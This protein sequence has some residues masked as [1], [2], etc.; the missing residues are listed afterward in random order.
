MTSSLLHSDAR[1]KRRNAAEK[2]FHLVKA[3]L[4]AH[5]RVDHLDQRT[6]ASHAHERPSRNQ[7]GVVERRD[8][9]FLGGLH[10]RRGAN[11]QLGLVLAHGVQVVFQRGAELH[12]HALGLQ[13][14]GVVGIP[15]CGRAGRAHVAQIGAALHQQTTHQQLG[16][17]VTAE[18]DAAVDFLL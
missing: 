14:L 13:P 8:A 12:L 5:G 6:G 17:F 2:R 3:V 11:G 1:T 16:A 15:R 18:R 9:R 4:V 10:H 7:V